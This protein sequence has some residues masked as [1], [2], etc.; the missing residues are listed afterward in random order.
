[1]RHLRTSSFRLA[2]NCLVAIRREGRAAL[3]RR[4]PAHDPL[5]LNELAAYGNAP[6][7][8]RLADRLAEAMW[9]IDEALAMCELEEEVSRWI[10]PQLRHTYDEVNGIMKTISN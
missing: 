5:D 6:L 2:I 1:M 8:V 3:D 9:A 7:F 10:E 4:R